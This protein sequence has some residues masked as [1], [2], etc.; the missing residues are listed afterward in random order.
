MRNY[1]SPRERR[2]ARNAKEKIMALDTWVVLANQ[3]DSEQAALADYDDVRTLY[4][5]LGIVD[6][7]DAAVLTRGAD[8]KVSIVKR[9]EEPTLH[10]AGIGLVVGLAVGA[11][12]AL[13]PAVTLGAG[14]I[15][16]SAIG[17]AAGAVAGHVARGM[18]RSDLKELGE[19]L[20]QGNSGLVVVAATDVEA[21]VNAAITRA[22][23]RAKAMVQADANALNAEIDR[24]AKAA[25]HGR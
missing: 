6:T 16:G 24:F 13:F 1:I 4:T 11:L 19:L 21:R 9:V 2:A 20:D 15:A 7:Y 17:A 22:Q 14:L 10:G 18:K 3:Y 8:G 23:K 12:V 25:G 5:Q